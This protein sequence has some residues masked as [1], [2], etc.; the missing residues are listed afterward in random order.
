MGE[1]GGKC[2][3]LKPISRGLTK[4]RLLG[5]IEAKT[6]SKG[7]VFLPAAFRKVLQGESSDTLVLRKDVYQPCLTL[8]TESA[9]SKQMDFLCSKINRWNPAHQQIY[10]QFLSA[11]DMITDKHFICLALQLFN[12]IPYFPMLLFSLLL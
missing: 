5:N 4:M 3:I 11:H 2:V 1:S 7:R 6:D 10:R 8:Y 9:W 12:S